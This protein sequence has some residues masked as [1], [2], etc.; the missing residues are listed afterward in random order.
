MIARYYKGTRTRRAWV[1]YKL[2]GGDIAATD[3]LLILAS[4]STHITE[5]SKVFSVQGMREA[6]KLAKAHNVEIYNAF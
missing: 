5:P 6:R 2:D 3:V 1:G 4:G